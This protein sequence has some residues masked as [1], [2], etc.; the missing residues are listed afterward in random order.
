MWK[1]F[2]EPDMPQ[3]TVRRMCVTCRITKAT[4]T[5]SEY[6]ILVAFSTATVVTR[7]HLNV[8]FIRTFKVDVFHPEAFIE[9]IG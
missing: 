5:H 4:D 2:F 9:Y 8:E 7:T 3:M 6:V 1:P